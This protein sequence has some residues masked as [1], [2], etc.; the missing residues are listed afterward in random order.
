MNQNGENMVYIFLLLQILKRKMT[1][2]LAKL[3][4][5]TPQALLEKKW[6]IRR[7]LTCPVSVN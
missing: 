5:T 3:T 6:N 4:L 7:Q 1:R 2:T